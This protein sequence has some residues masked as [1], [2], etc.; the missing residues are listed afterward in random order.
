MDSRG[1]N[2]LVEKV[3][4]YR[5]M[6]DEAFPDL[7]AG[8]RYSRVAAALA[9]A[10][11]ERTVLASQAPFQLWL[12]GERSAMSSGEKAGAL[13]FLGKAGCHSCHTGPALNSMR[14]EALRMRDLYQLP[15]VF[16]S[17][18][19][20]VHN[21]GRGGFTDRPEDVNAFKVPQLYNLADARFYGH[22]GSFTSLREVS[23]PTRTRRRPRTRAF[24]HTS[25]LHSFGRSG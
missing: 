20:S 3:P 8:R 13:L 6:F 7:P 2:R 4:A 10:A 17:S 14:F 22:G 19:D 16:N 1:F 5:A 12:R 24:P 18:A 15:G 23:W 9:I 25:S 11:N 21:E